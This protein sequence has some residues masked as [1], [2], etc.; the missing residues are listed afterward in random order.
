VELAGGK[1]Q[2]KYPALTGP[3][4]KHCDEYGIPTRAVSL[5]Y[6]IRSQDVGLGMPFN[7]ASYGLL[8]M[9]IAKN[10]N[11]LPDEL[12]SNLGDAHIYSN[13]VDALKEQLEREPFPLPQM[14]IGCDDVADI[15]D[16]TLGD[17]ML[18]GY[19]SHGTIKMPLSN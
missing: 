13:H 3:Q 7:L 5:M 19:Q 6:N 12:I 10:V 17:F 16:H 1:I 15:S 14:S 11:M 18:T 9:M 2:E 8:L 4:L